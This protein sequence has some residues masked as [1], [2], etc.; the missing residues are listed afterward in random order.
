MALQMD[1]HDGDDGGGD[2]H[3]HLHREPGKIFIKND[4]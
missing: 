1:Y 2:Y 3:H 4:G